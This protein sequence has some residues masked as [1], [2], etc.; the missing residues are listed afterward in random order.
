VR[1]LL[2][3][4]AVVAC[5][6]PALALAAQPKKDSAF[7]WCEN[8]NSCPLGFETNPK[9]T[10]IID[11]R[12]YNKCAQ[13]PATYPK[14][15]VK[16]D[17]TFSKSGNVTDVTGNK[18]NYKIEGKFK[19]PKKAVGTY[20]IDAKGCKADAQKFVAKRVGKAQPGI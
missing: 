15:K 16:D 18:L 12:A 5:V 17:G 6:V 9:G 8:K 20:D 7:Q 19:K 3:T 14:I 1:K 4:L 13:V 2:L 11:I 10:K